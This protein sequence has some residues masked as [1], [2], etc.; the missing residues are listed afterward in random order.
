MPRPLVRHLWTIGRAIVLV[1]VLLL[2]LIQTYGLYIAAAVVPQQSWR[3]RMNFQLDRALFTMDSFRLTEHPSSPAM[4]S[5]PLIAHLFSPA[6]SGAP[7]GRERSSRH[8][9]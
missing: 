5:L 7:H 2:L 8:S 9:V 3:R 1:V 6:A 4:P